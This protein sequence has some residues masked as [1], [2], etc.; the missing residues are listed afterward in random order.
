MEPEYNTSLINNIKINKAVYIGAGTDIIP[1]IVLDNITE[2]IYIDSQPQSECGMLFYENYVLFRDYFIPNFQKIMA[3]NNFTL[4]QNKNNYLEFKNTNGKIIKYFINTPFPEK[5]T[6]EIKKELTDSE[7]LILSGFDPNKVV[8]E[9]MPNLKNIY[10]VTHTVY[11]CPDNEFEDEESMNNSV[12]R[13]LVKNN[14]KYN[15][16]LI[17]ENKY[18]EYWINDNIK[19]TIKNIFEISKFDDLSELYDESKKIFKQFA[20]IYNS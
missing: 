19:P 11:D 1:V 8:L 15:Y 18:F 7:N 12:F 3:N 16:Y 6:D 2:Y 13:E 4:T 5:L 20:E 17:K 14:Q 9:L 10:G